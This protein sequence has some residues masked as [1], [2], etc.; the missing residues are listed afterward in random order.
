MFRAIEGRWGSREVEIV[1][2]EFIGGSGQAAH[3][4]PS[5]DSVEIRLQVQAHSPVTDLVFGVS[6][7]NVDGVCCYGTNTDIEG[8][9]SGAISGHGG[10]S[11]TIDRLDL[12]EGTYKVDVAVHRKN[13]APYDYHRLLHTFRVTST[14]KDIGIFR[15][16]HRWTF[17]GGVRI[18]GLGPTEGPASPGAAS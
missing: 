1:T 5:G 17:S 10:V 8:A 12:V 13:G 18:T 9:E 3:V 11:F 4:F 16:A 7:F 14:M 2:V 6:I 15:P